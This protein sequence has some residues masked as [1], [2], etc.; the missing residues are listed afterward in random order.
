MAYDDHFRLLAETSFADQV[1][2]IKKQF[3]LYKDYAHASFDD[4]FKGK[5]KDNLLQFYCDETRSCYFENP[6][7]G[8]FI[9]HALPIEANL[10]R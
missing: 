9:K 7:N 8:K 6:G 4:I 5:A 1:P 10:H 3:L 2:A